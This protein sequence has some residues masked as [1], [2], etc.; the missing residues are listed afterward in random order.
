MTVFIPEDK[1]LEIKNAAD[2]VDVISESVLL[3]KAGK[4]YIGLCP[5]HSEKTPSFTVSPQKQI[6]YCFGCAAGG[7]V[8]SFIMKRDGITFPEAVQ[9]LS[10]QYGISIPLKEMTGAQQKRRSEREELFAVNRL[11]MDYFHKTLLNPAVGSLAAAYL[12][13]RGIKQ[14]TIKTFRVGYAPEGWNNLVNFFQKKKMPLYIVEKAGLI[15]ERGNKRG[16]YDR[17]RKRI[18]FPIFNLNMQVIGFGGRVMNDDMPKYLNSPETMVYNKS[19]SLYGLH[20]SKQKS[21][22]EETVY[23]AEGYFDLLAMHQNGIDN[24][25]ATLGTSLTS[26]HV[27]IIRG[28]VGKDG[29]AVLVFDSDDA[30][31]NAALRSIGIFLNAGLDAR[32]MVLPSGYDPDSYLLEYGQVSFLD[33]AGKAKTIMSFLM[34]ALIEKHGMSV[35]GKVRVVS[36]MKE[37][38]LAIEDKMAR[39]LYIKELAERLG[40]E[41]VAVLEKMRHGSFRAGDPDEKNR[42]LDHNF[43]RDYPKG[44]SPKTNNQKTFYSKWEKLEQQIIKMMLQFPTILSE[45]EERKI[46]SFFEDE[47]LK[48]IGQMILSQKDRFD[49]GFADLIDLIAEKDQKSI[50]AA[51]AIEESKWDYAGCL[52]ILTRF[53][54][55]RSKNK[56]TLINK[57]KEAE[58][59]KD[60]EL[61]EKLLSEKQ[62]MA[63]LTE[64]KKMT[65]LK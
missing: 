43:I 59:N 45:I 16:F 18:I 63:V 4:N 55:I 65:L 60:Y 37:T 51:M 27:Q 64:K 15:V 33:I 7:N 52:A 50:I 22:D 14:E 13:K 34:D 42:I 19:R 1:I 25:V 10:R 53:E 8:F 2:I 56:K 48:S 36:E 23:I 49:G 9:I 46:L 58:E 39:S 5:F 30:G 47:R 44:A 28:L 54:S 24:S 17:F 3:K 26:E 12:E 61:L 32:I 38:L 57:I 31:I 35:S 11:A 21:R 6:F 62:K 29:N 20:L 41:E 40:I